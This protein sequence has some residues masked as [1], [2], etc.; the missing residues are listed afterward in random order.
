MTNVSR[1]TRKVNT[2]VGQIKEQTYFVFKGVNPKNVKKQVETVKEL[3][4]KYEEL[5][6]E[7]NDLDKEQKEASLKMKTKKGTLDKKKKERV[8]YG[9]TKS[10]IERA[11]KKLEQLRAEAAGDIEEER[12]TLTANLKKWIE[13]TTK[14]SADANKRWRQLMD[15]TFLVSGIVVDFAERQDELSRVDD[16]LDEEEARAKAVKEAYEEAKEKFA[17]CKSNLRE[18]K[19]IAD[20][21]APLVDEAGNDLPIKAQLDELPG[22]LFEVQS[23]IKDCREQINRVVDDPHLLAEYERT[24]KEI[25]ELTEALAN[26][27]E[28]SDAKK[29]EMMSLEQPFL[30]KLTNFLA[31]ID[32]R[33]GQYM[34]DLS[35]AGGIKLNKGEDGYTSWGIDIQVKYRH[36]N[37][38]SVLDARVHSGGE[39]R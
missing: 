11:E 39:R 13:T 22:Q 29:A 38:L 28:V 36:A 37:A 24:K 19:K 30:A 23:A 27:S 31:I 9:K 1:Y 16:L 17:D 32:E 26:K 6:E 8:Q 25:E 4:E 5:T 33:F 20:T 2:S 12:R 3:K 34:N 10:D 21:E 7:I 15:N 35:C 14:S 18:L